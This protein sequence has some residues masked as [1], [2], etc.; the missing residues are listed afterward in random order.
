MS[1]LNLRH[2]SGWVD[3]PCEGTELELWFGP[4]NTDLPQELRETPSQ[5][6]F[7]ERTAK[8]VCSECPFVEPC[9]EEE[10]AF[11]IGRQFGVRA[12]LTAEERQDLLRQRRDAVA[13]GEVA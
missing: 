2:L 6:A 3:R 7:R 1:H 10:L 8:G 11:G 5:R 12:G 13:Q 4:E 9:L